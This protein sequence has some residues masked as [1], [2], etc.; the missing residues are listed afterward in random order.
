MAIAAEYD[1]E[2]E[3]V[4]VKGAYLNGVL[5]EVIYMHQPEGFHDGSN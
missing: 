2:M 5:D 3:I 1:M 4:D